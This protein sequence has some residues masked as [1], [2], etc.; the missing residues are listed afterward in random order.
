[1]N[2]SQKDIH[3]KNITK[4]LKHRDLHLTMHKHATKK[5]KKGPLPQT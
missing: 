2:S 4:M 1:M 3:G 5:G